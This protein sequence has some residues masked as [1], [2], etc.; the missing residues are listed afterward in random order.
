M[1]RRYAIISPCR[2]EA[3]FLQTT[4]DA[5]AAQTVPPTL[6]LVVDDGSTDATPE[7]L[8]RAAERLPFLRVL[9]RQDRGARAVGPGVVEAFYAGLETIDLDDYDYI[10]KLDGDLDLPPR[11]FER[12][13]ERF[14]ADP[15]LGNLSGKVFLREHGKLIPERVG[16]ENAVGMVK[17]YRV[18]CFRDIGGFVRQVS[19]DG[20][21]GHMC[22][23]RGWIAS[24]VPDEEMYV[25]HLRLMGS[26]Q[27]SIWEGRLRWGRGK[28]FMGSAPYYVAA[29]AAYRLFERPFVFGGLCIF[30]G[31]VRAWWRGDARHDD[32]EYRRYMRRYELQSLLF[33]K[34][35]TLQ[36]Y[37]DRIRA[38]WPPPDQ[39]S[40]VA[41]ATA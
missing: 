13:F 10:C 1:S 26:S 32:R 6:W 2:D 21:D 35:R 4:I 19:W 27:H 31:Y 7:I 9:R 28:Y 40:T 17:L 23:M 39:R 15:W 14:E 38:D 3:E 22:R 11:Y 8:A 12:A 25:V 18:A 33:G 36:R 41:A 24:S 34:R 29:V 5:M 20:I 37:N 16:D 30:W